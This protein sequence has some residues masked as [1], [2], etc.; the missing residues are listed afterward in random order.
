MSY[1]A[2]AWTFYAPLRGL[3]ATGSALVARM[4]HRCHALVCH[5]PQRHL[6]HQHPLAL[7][8]GDSIMSQRQDSR[9]YGGDTSLVPRLGEIVI[10]MAKA[11]P[12][13]LG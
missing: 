10:I 4:V 9:W 3:Q 7:L 5:Y 6:A 13:M 2:E 11:E 12:R 1:R 8:R